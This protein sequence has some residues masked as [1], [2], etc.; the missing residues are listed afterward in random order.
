VR[1]AHEIAVIGVGNTVAGD[2]GAGLEALRRIEARHRGN[3]RFLFHELHGDLYAISE[4]LPLARRFV[5]LDAV[6]GTPPGE[7]V[8]TREAPRAHTPS[9]HQADIAAVMATM[10]RLGMTDQFPEW[11]IWGVAI[12]PPA[13]L[14]IGLS[15][16]VERGVTRLVDALDAMLRSL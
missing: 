10:E 5:F 9:F 14:R 15:P 1:P 13:E 16:A 3:P 11:E 7:L 12:D 2:D 8:V 4:L 6:C